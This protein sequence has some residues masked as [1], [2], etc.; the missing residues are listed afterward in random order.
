MYLF[1]KLKAK[2]ALG[3]KS[4]CLLFFPGTEMPTA[5]VCG[6][7]LHFSCSGSQAPV[8]VDECCLALF[9][10]VS[11]VTAWPSL[12]LTLSEEG[13]I[14]LLSLAVGSLWD[15]KRRGS[16]PPQ[17]L[18]L[19]CH[20]GPASSFWRVD[21]PEDEICLFHPCFYC[22]FLHKINELWWLSPSDLRIPWDPGFRKG[23]SLEMQ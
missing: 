19:H 18:S 20:L 2:M 21:S 11:N 5:K 7:S 3:E 14:L 4:N 17:Y 16:R 15:G 13:G 12:C 23:H 22:L 8:L 1:L 10:D 9:L 6:N